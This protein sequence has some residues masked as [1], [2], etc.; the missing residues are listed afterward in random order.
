MGAHESGLMNSVPKI[1]LAIPARLNSVRFPKKILLN[2]DGKTLVERVWLNCQAIKDFVDEIVVLVD[3]AGVAKVVESFGGK[4]VI[5]PAHLMNGTQRV[6]FYAQDRDFDFYINCQGDDPTIPPSLLMRVVD[7]VKSANS[8]LLTVVS[9]SSDK[10]FYDSP[11][12]VKVVLDREG[13]AIY[14]SRYPIPFVRDGSIPQESV[15]TTPTASL[16]LV[17]T[18]IYA[19]HAK[20]LALYLDSAPTMLE[21]VENLEQLRFMELG[22]KFDVIKDNFVGSPIDVLGDELVAMQKLRDA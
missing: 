3:D 8:N 16:K 19:Y 11:S 12:V 10:A 5:T 14:F 18:G 9:E 21:I 17:H 2:L 7:A 22:E 15:V 20:M 1:C 13:R 6:A 4:A